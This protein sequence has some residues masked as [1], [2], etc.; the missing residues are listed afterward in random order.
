[1]IEADRAN[2]VE[3]AQI[4]FIRHVVA[5]PGHHVEGRMIQ[6]AP[7][8]LTE[9]FLH[10]RGRLREVLVMGDRSQEIPRIR[11]AIAA[12]GPEVRQA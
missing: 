6:L 3:A 8:Q 7:P 4:I 10:Q 12:D 1:M 9:E 11:Q 2:G 5:V